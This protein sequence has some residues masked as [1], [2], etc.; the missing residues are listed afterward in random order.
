MS[1]VTVFLLGIAG[2]VAVA[3]LFGAL[4]DQITY[5]ISPEYYTA[6][7]FPQFGLV[8]DVEAGVVDL[9]LRVALVGVL[10]TW[11]VGLGLG[12]VLAALALIQRDGRA[13]ARVLVTGAAIVVVVATAAAIGG[14][15]LWPWFVAQGLEVPTPRAV[16]DR[17]AFGR[18]GVIH[19]FSYLGG[20]A[21]GVM[22][23]LFGLIYRVTAR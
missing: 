10:A 6:L 13:M 12:A 17:A 4:H 18:V 14:W 1:K 2:S 23:A 9:R 16:I 22:A 15:A 3:S 19:T 21:G 20:A 5:T 7:K 8:P 11:W